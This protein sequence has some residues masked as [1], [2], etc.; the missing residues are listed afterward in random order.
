MVRKRF[1]PY[2]F[3]KQNFLARDSCS[4]SY[5]FLHLQKEEFQ[6]HQQQSPQ[7]DILFSQ[8]HSTPILIT[9]T[10]EI[11]SMLSTNLFPGLPTVYFLI[12]TGDVYK[13]F[14]S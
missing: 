13:P 3:K 12:I 14:S 2:T 6:Q 8:S 4:S 5:D 10:P 1:K 7:L 11:H 9:Y